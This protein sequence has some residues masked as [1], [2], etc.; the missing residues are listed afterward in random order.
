MEN[1]VSFRA[2]VVEKGE[3]EGKKLKRLMERV[4]LRIGGFNENFPGFDRLG[5]R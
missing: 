5:F 2:L 3:G 1:T 4:L